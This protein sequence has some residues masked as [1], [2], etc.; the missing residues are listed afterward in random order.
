MYSPFANLTGFNK[1]ATVAI[2]Q[3]DFF[4]KYLMP[5]SCSGYIMLDSSIFNLEGSSSRR[6]CLSDMSIVW[7]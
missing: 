6:V 5:L 7:W 2:N 1:G 3:G 4:L